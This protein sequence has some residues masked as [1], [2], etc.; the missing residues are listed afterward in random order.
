M[1]SEGLLVLL[2]TLTSAKVRWFL[3]GYG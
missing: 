3:L 2:L 1:L